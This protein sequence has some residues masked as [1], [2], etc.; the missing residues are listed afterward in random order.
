MEKKQ[1]AVTEEQNKEAKDRKAQVPRRSMTDKK[2]TEC[3]EQHIYHLH[4]LQSYTLIGKRL[5]PRKRA[6]CTFVAR[7]A[8]DSQMENVVYPETLALLT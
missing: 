2:Q 6:L 1:K 4:S 5:L 8:T 3:R 7:S